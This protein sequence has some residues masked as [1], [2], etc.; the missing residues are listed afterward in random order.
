MQT[1]QWKTHFSVNMSIVHRFGISSQPCRTVI[2]INWNKNVLQFMS[3]LDVTCIVDM[4]ENK[5]NKSQRPLV[6]CSSISFPCA[7]AT[8]GDVIIANNS[9][10]WNSIGGLEIRTNTTA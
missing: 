8:N 10:E 9:K 6:C 1:K 3:S 5:R 2:G 7:V 4:Y